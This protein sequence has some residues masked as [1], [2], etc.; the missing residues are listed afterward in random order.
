MDS[1]VS[2][3]VFEELLHRVVLTLGY[4]N[5]GSALTRIDNTLRA[6]PLV[7]QR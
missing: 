4:E 1:L 2:S 5:V 6:P 3:F 7:I